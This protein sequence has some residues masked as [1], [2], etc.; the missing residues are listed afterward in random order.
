MNKL[1]LMCLVAIT[2]LSCGSLSTPTGV[3]KEF[4]KRM[5]QGKIEEAK[6]LVTADAAAI[7]NMAVLAGNNDFQN[8]FSKI[9]FEKEVIQGNEAWVYY[10]KAGEMD[11]NE[12][13]HLKL[14]DGKWKIS[15]EMH[16]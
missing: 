15:L 7:M 9:K 1:T 8:K 6:Q 2:L 13:M 12:R 4:V 16:K 3:A 5:E 14:I 10:K 11:K